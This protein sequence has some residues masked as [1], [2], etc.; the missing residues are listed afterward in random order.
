MSIYLIGVNHTTA[1][2]STDGTPQSEDQKNYVESLTKAIRN[3][4]AEYVAEEYSEEAEQMTNR[5]SLTPKVAS[6]NGAKML[7]QPSLRTA[8]SDC[9][10]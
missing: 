9:L 2:S 6:E 4:D 3:V 7:S 1:Q 10:Y 5:L 8:S